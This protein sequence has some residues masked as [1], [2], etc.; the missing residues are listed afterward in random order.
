MLK[1]D[2]CGKEKA[3]YK[4]FGTNKNIC[5]NCTGNFFVCTGCGTIYEQDDF[6]NGDNGNGFCKRNCDNK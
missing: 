1:C 5:S 2:I 6:E 3:V 4:V